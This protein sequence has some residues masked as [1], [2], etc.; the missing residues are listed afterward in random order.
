MFFEKSSSFDRNFNHLYLGHFLR[1]LDQTW[2]D[3]SSLY[4]EC[5][6]FEL[7]LIAHAQWEK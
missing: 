1:K 6:H 2:Y 5:V 7:A 3:Y 4:K